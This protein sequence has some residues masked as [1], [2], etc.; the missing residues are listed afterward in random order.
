V[1]QRREHLKLLGIKRVAKVVSINDIL[2]QA[3]ESHTNGIEQ[4]NGQA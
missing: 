3:H 2:S 1:A 4:G